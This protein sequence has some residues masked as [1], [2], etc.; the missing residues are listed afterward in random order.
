MS[1]TL[2]QAEALA[3]LVGERRY[4]DER[5]AH[6]WAHKG[7]PAISGELTLI[8]S[9]FR[10][11]EDAYTDSAG[12]ENAMQVLRKIGGLALRAIEHYG[13]PKTADYHLP[14]R[15]GPLIPEVDPAEA[16]GGAIRVDGVH[17][18]EEA[19]AR[20]AEERKFQDSSKWAYLPKV[21]TE[22]M[23]I[24]KYLRA[25]DEAFCLGHGREVMMYIRIVGAICVRAIEV[26]GCPERTQ[27][28]DL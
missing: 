15:D 9:Y 21:T 25:A 6:E 4:Q 26:H 8:N 24:R 1:K 19:F 23:L 3:R 5:S 2:T 7:F 10:K 12:D 16:V 27:I 11:A 20:L 14:I 28:V 13:C 22:L 17:T 18:T